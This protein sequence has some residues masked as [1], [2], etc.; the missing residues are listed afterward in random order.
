MNGTVLSLDIGGSFIKC[1]L[2][3]R[4]GNILENT[5]I[6]TPSTYVEFLSSIKKLAETIGKSSD[7]AAVAIPGGYDFKNGKAFAP[8]LTIINGQNIK[9]DIEN[10]IGKKTVLENDANLAALGEYVFAENKEPRDLLLI[11]LGTGVGGGL[12]IGGKLLSKDV[13]VFE[14]GHISI[15]RNGPLCGC[16]RR[17]CLDEYCSVTGLQQIYDD[18]AGVKNAEPKTIGALA[19]TGDKKAVQTLKTYGALL[20]EA[21]LNPANLFVPEKIKIGGGLSEL[22]DYFLPDCIEAFEKNIFPAYKGRVQIEKATLKNDA[23]IMGGAALFFE[24]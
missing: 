2:V 9:K 12:I 22:S 20:G 21:L 7:G 3:D 8:N 23:G 17:G 5:R 6:H 16:G 10:V 14:V 11:T 13:T 18:V 1:G 24:L 4:G 19:A 15:D